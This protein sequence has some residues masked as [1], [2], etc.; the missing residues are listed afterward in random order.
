MDLPSYRC[1][2]TTKHATATIDSWM[3]VHWKFDRCVICAWF[4]FLPS[5]FEHAEGIMKEPDTGIRPMTS[6]S[7]AVV[8]EV[9]D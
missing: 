7:S 3:Q 8:L 6:S 9:G 2:F 4:H 1:S 5:V